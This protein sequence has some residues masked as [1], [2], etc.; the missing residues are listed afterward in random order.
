[1]KKILFIAP[2]LTL[3]MA[4]CASE[5]PTGSKGEL[6]ED[7]AKAYMSISMVTPPVVM[8]R[9]DDADT[10]KDP[11]T[12]TNG[13]YENG[14]TAENGVTRVRFYFFDNG[15]GAF[16]VYKNAADGDYNNYIDWYPAADDYGP[17]DPNE[18][19]EKEIKATVAINL[20]TSEKPAQVVAIL[21][22]TTELLN[23]PNSQG[24][25]SNLNGIS[26]K[27]LKDQVNNYCT[28]L[29]SE[30]KFVMSN[31][32]YVDG[33]EVQYATEVKPGNICSTVAAALANPVTI[34]VERV[35]ARIDVGIAASLAAGGIKELDD[36]DKTILYKLQSQQINDNGAEEGPEY[37]NED[38]YVKLLGWNATTTTN[39]SRLIKDVDP[40]WEPYQILGKNMIWN[41]AD[42]HRSFWAINPTGVTYSY[43]NLLGG[44]YPAGSTGTNVNPA[45]ANKFLKTGEYGKIYV[46]ENAAPITELTS[47][48]S[49]PTQ[50]IVAAQLCD[51]DGNGLTLAQWR[52]K[53]YTL[54]G[55]KNQLATELQDLC[56]IEKTGT[57]TSYSSIEPEDL[58]FTQTAPAGSTD[59]ENYYVYVT[60]TPEAA[61]NYNWA[62]R[63][64]NS[65]APYDNIQ[66]VYTYILNRT[67]HVKIW[68]SGYAYY[69][70][71]I[72]HLGVED[73]DPG[74]LGIVRNHIYRINV[75]SFN[76]FGCPVFDPWQ[77]IIPEP[78]S[79]DASVMSAE[80]EILQWRVVS[81]EFVLTW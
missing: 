6:P 54:N 50:L 21:N 59:T 15:G 45:N 80:V 47:G 16:P 55:L 72:R 39:S 43:G 18:T 7:G 29:T 46:Q 58:T 71:D 22:P 35:V 40:S 81:Q 68:T 24:N 5:E 63:N 31:S 44:S 57:G 8:T 49:N 74:Y 37:Y 13:V 38:I 11:A 3:L 51:E 33:G 70:L 53:T 75:T 20:P 48:P 28:G 42:F 17:G 26:L 76:G 41:T 60:L 79:P 23:L 10:P 56:K 4:S 30:G 65:Y 1:M 32:I 69:Y 61:G 73:T 78:Q 12:E 9:D 64:G 14:T 19:V 36:A 2:A 34:Y 25:A 67:D 66:G 52:N 27:T 77:E 62:L